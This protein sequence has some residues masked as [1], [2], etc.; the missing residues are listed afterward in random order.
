MQHE[1]G[2]AGSFRGMGQRKADAG[3]E[4]A[5]PAPREDPP[6][7]ADR[8][9]TLRPPGN[10][11]LRV[12]NA[13]RYAPLLLHPSPEPD[14][15]PG[16]VRRPQRGHGYR[17]CLSRVP[18]SPPLSIMPPRGAVG[19]CE[20]EV[21]GAAAVARQRAFLP[22]ARSEPVWCPEAE[23]KLRERPCLAASR[24]KVKRGTEGQQEPH[25][26]TRPQAP[27]PPLDVPPFDAQKLGTQCMT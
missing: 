11:P 17:R 10:R 5:T 15:S 26:G 14:L 23:Q 13:S 4:E 6:R 2:H 9:T 8:S 1:T 12:R 16:G 7:R 27:E 21:G 3:R 18:A 22:G 20:P 25:C 19:N 24:G